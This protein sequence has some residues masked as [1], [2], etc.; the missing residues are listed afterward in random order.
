MKN[1]K[2][3]G[4]GALCV[5]SLLAGCG[6]Q[7]GDMNNNDKNADEPKEISLEQV[8]ADN[9]PE[10]LLE[11]HDTVTVSIQGTDQDSKETYTA[12]VQ[13]TRDDKGN[14]LLASHY[15]YTADS[16]V[17]EDDFFAQACLSIEG[18]G[19]YLSKMESDGRLNMNCYPSGEYE[20]YIL[21]MLPAC[22]EADNSAS[23]TIDEQSEQ[24]GAVL[25]STTTTYSDMPDYYYTTLYYADPETG[26]LLA[27]SVTDYIE[28]GE[29]GATE[30]GTT[31]YNWSYD[32]PYKTEPYKSGRYLLN[33]VVYA[34]DD[35]RPACLLTVCL[36]AEEGGEDWWVNEYHVARGTYVNICC[37]SGCTL[38]ADAALTQPIDDTVS[39]DTNG[40]EMT[41][42]VV[43]DVP[44]N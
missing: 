42:Y 34:T 11:D 21:D 15:S 3:A 37:R 18:N 7:D 30:M 31:L 36:P 35:T 5:M 19:V 27:M 2:K 33:D 39:I 28:D 16:P 10:K 38:Y 13:Y 1:W 6:M 29:G 17:G 25:I 40:E 26:E 8:R 43:P 9:I 41:V 4:I 24:D 22:R 12:K 14:L 23:E 44:L 20:M 32:E